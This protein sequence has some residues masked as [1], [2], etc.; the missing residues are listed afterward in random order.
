MSLALKLAGQGRDGVK[1]NPMVGCVVVKDDKIVAKGY[2]QT[3]GGKSITKLMVR[4][5]M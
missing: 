5:F 4:H 3:F 2:H 1:A